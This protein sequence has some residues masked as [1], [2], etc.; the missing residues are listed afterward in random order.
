MGTAAVSVW[1]YKGSMAQLLGAGLLNAFGP[2]QSGVINDADGQLTQSDD[3]ISQ[4]TLGTGLPTSIDYIG[5]GTMSLASLNFLGIPLVT[6]SPVPAAAFQSDGKIWLLLPNGFPNLLGLNLS[7]LSA[8]FNLS[9]SSAFSLSSFVPCFLEG[10]HLMT[11][12]G[13]AAVEDLHRGDVVL[14]HLG[15]RHSILWHGVTH[16]SA[17]AEWATDPRHPV[18]IP[19]G[20]FGP[21]RPRRDLLVSQ[22]HRI[23]L[24]DNGRDVFTKAKFLVPAAAVIDRSR[25]RLAYHHILTAR[26]ATLMTENIP[27]ESFFP[28]PV[29][30]DGLDVK[31]A[32]LVRHALGTTWPTLAYPEINRQKTARL[33]AD[34]AAAERAFFA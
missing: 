10:T 4:F 6:L 15:R 18:R 19:A 31:S 21:G 24:H 8:S 1:Q 28:G 17:I 20:A 23:L 5:A 29:A 22:Q 16:V 32:A 30:M 2:Q 13:E 27:T 33:L 14:D 7:S 3:S 9:P 12:D 34:N 11:D 26:H 25:T